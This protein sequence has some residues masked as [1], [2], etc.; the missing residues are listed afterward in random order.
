MCIL[1]N[2]YAN[3]GG[4]VPSINACW[5]LFGAEKYESST[6]HFSIKI[7]SEHGFRKFHVTDCGLEARLCLDLKASVMRIRRHLL[8]MM[9][10]DL[11]VWKLSQSVIIRPADDAVDIKHSA[12]QRAIRISL[13]QSTRDLV[14]EVCEPYPPPLQSL[15]RTGELVI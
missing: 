13:P 9:P 5:R 7:L 11:V 10:Y 2:L 1:G 3:S 12:V 14:F 6:P 8:N 15:L 4:D